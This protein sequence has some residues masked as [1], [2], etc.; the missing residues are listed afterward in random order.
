MATKKGLTCGNGSV[1]SLTFHKFWEETSIWW[2]AK[3]L[4]LGIFSGDTETNL[5]WVRPG[6]VFLDAE[7][8]SDSS[9][10]FLIFL[11]PTVL[12]SELRTYLS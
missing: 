7:M 12:I 9:L 5:L 3:L 6:F 1:I 8:F 11:R 10:I 2:K 4:N